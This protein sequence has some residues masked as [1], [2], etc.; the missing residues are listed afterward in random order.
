MAT[1]DARVPPAPH[2]AIR[3]R[4]QPHYLGGACQCQVKEARLDRI[5]VPDEALVS[6]HLAD[7]C[8]VDS[9]PD[10]PSTISSLPLRYRRTL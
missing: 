2:P 7:R 1:P 5:G 9:S 10:F 8:L 3:E 4:D 6:I